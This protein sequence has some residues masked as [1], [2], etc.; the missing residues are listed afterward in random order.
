LAIIRSAALLGVNGL[1]VSV[2]V[3]VSQGLPGFTIVGLPDAA[4][5]EARDRVR[6]AVLSSKLTW[7]Q[8]RVT[9]NLAPSGLRKVGTGLDLAIAVGLLV[10]SEQAPASATELGYLGEL[11]LDGAVRP[12]SGALPMSVAIDA[13]TLVV[14]EANGTEANLAC[15]DR[16]RCVASLAELL[17]CLEG[18]NVWSAPPY[19]EPP[20]EA[21]VLDLAEVRGNDVARFALEVAAAGGHHLLFVGPPGAG[22]TML[23][24]R[25]VGLLEPLDRDAALRVT[26][27]HSAAGQLLP[28]DGLI[29]R[30]PFRAPHHTVSQVALVGGGSTVLRP[31]EI[32]L[33][34]DGL[35]FLDELGEFSAHALDALRQPLEEG[36]VR[37][38]RAGASAEM[39]ADFQL[40]AAMNPCPCGRGGTGACRCSDAG[41]ARYR[42]RVSGPLLDRFDLRVMVHPV[43]SDRLVCTTP[44][45]STHEV[46]RRVVAARRR[47]RDRGVRSNHAMPGAQLETVARLDAD[48]TEV[49]RRAVQDGRLSGRGM[50]RVHSVALT[51]ADLAGSDGPIDE[52]TV[53]Q[54][55]ALRAEIMVEPSLGLTA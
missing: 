17:D 6:A 12:I 16:V 8:S 7:P 49:L 50:R 48:A 20:P 40:I 30:A 45:E 52:A 1:P 28:P 34:S 33:A 18:R 25:M 15:P 19:R 24:E 5:R 44:G 10:A 55:L 38:S 47:A 4:C 43:T 21:P 3:H 2:E 41:L 9:V 14:A 35:L 37:I 32:T 31:G 29:R 11:G 54:A 23:A 22:K 53:A 51:I 46:R 39:P 13:P 26:A 42:R 36:V 27:A